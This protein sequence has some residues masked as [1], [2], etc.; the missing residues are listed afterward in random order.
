[1]KSPEAIEVTP[2]NVTKSVTVALAA[3]MVVAAEAMLTADT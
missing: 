2:V 3:V 1:M